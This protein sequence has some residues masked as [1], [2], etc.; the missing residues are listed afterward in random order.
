MAVASANGLKIEYETAGDP[1]DPALLL[2]TG[3]SA[4][5]V[6]WERPFIDALVAGGRYVIVF[7]NRDTGLSTHLDG[8]IPDIAGIMTA[9]AAGDTPKGA[10][11]SL[12]DMAADAFGLLD[13][14]D[15]RQVDVVGE[16]MGGM[17]AQ[18]MAIER[19]ER[20]RTITAIMSHAGDPVLGQPDPDVAAAMLAPSPSDRDGFIERTVELVKLIGGTRYFDRDEAREMAVASFDR[21]HYPEGAL[22]HYAAVLSAPSRVE[23]LRAVQVPTLVIHG[24]ADRVVPLAGGEQIAASVPGASMLEL[25]DMGHGRPS[26][27]RPI[28]ADAILSHTRHAMS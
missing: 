13:H 6:V 7:D 25:N 21:C 8:V 12:S 10:P 5:L 4:Q 27:L 3:F 23:Q 26:A 14:L 1:T 11:Y 19:P 28:I 20:V 22:R 17:I 18:I 24:R 2:I 9:L 15:V 16:S